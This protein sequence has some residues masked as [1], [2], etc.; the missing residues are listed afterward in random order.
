MHLS[1]SHICHSLNFICI[2]K[3][4]TYI[5]RNSQKLFHI[6]RGKHHPNW[7]T[8]ASFRWRIPWTFSNTLPNGKIFIIF[9]FISSL[10]RQ[11]FIILIF[12]SLSRNIFIS[13]IRYLFISFIRR[14]FIIFIRR[15][16]ISLPRRLFISLSLIR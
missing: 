14:L 15:L 13:L 10:I 5:T 8:R 11:I 12:S 1:L 3:L 4:L 7:F 16:F 9:H 2:K 6:Y